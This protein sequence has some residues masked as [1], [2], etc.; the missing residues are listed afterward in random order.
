MFS[1]ANRALTINNEIAEF[2]NQVAARFHPDRIILFG[3]HAY[4][5]PNADSDVDLLVVMLHEGRD[6]AK[7]I[8]IQL[9][10]PAKFPM[11]LIVRKPD[12]YRSRIEQGD[13]FLQEISSKGKV[14]YDASY[15]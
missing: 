5:V 9:E 10:I 1:S 6:A 2:A 7:S 8:E 12:E 14:L 4:G 15:L 13:F 3:S 11:D